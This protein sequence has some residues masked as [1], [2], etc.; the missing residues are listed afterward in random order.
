MERELS[1]QQ[2][3]VLLRAQLKGGTCLSTTAF[4]ALFDLGVTLTGSNQASILASVGG[5]LRSLVELG[6]IVKSGPG[7]YH[8]TEE[9]FRVARVAQSRGASYPFA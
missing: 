2:E 6:L 8:L 3:A 4:S 9:G 1:K 5:I 7:E